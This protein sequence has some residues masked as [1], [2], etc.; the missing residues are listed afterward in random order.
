MQPNET[1]PEAQ[2]HS[3]NEAIASIHKIN[4]VLRLLKGESVEDL[5]KELGV[6]IRRIERWRSEFVEAG[7][8]ALSRRRDLD[9]PG[10]LGRHST[11]IKQWAWLLAILIGLITL[12]V[13]LSQRGSGD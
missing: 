11:S 3:R 5:S 2:T 10:W 13:T 12:L 4:A 7:S 1:H 8:G 6:S 9:S